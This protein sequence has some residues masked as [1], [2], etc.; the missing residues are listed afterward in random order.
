MR[1]IVQRRYG[2]PDVLALD[3]VADPVAGAGQVVVDVAASSV[4]PI[5]WKRASGTYRLV[6]PVTFPAVPGYDVAG[7]V[8][9]VGNGVDFSKGDRVH[10]RIGDAAGGACAARA[11]VGVDVVARM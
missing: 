7:T 1:A 5:D 6:L 11:V 4:N 10:A 8:V 9:A 2:G 3:D